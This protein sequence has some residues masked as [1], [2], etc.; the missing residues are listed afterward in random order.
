MGLPLLCLAESNARINVDGRLR[1]GISENR[2][3]AKSLE[4]AAM[5]INASFFSS[6]LSG[7][8]MSEHPFKPK[9]FHEPDIFISWLSR[10]AP[11][12]IKN[13]EALLFW[14]TPLSQTPGFVLGNG[15]LSWNRAVADPMIGML[16][17]SW[18]NFGLAG[19]IETAC[20]IAE[21]MGGERFLDERILMNTEAS[22]ISKGRSV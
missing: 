22:T 14:I 13:D 10:H 18:S 12:S 17:R 4:F 15:V 7:N 6:A 21:T 9:Y 16:F 20:N 11:F 19:E 5:A 1:G 2:W 8:D 3:K